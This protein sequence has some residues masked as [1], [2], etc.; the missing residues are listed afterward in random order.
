MLGVRQRTPA[1]VSKYRNRVRE[2]AGGNGRGGPGHTRSLTH[3]V[4][5]GHRFPPENID[6]PHASST[7][8]SSRLRTRV[9]IH[10]EFVASA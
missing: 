7:V 1:E 5:D 8:A 3:A 9:R 10:S 6:A 4:P 2:R